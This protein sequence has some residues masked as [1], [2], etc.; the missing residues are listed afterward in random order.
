[1]RSAP[2][3]IPGRGGAGI[4]TYIDEATRALN[5][6]GHTCHLL[7]WSYD[8]GADS[9]APV[10]AGLFLHMRA[11]GPCPVE[12]GRVFPALR[13]SQLVAGWVRGLHRQF[14][15]DYAEFTDWMAPAYA[16]LQLRSIDSDLR[17]LK[18]TVFNH[19]LTYIIESNCSRPFGHAGIGRGMPARVRR[20]ASRAR[21]ERRRAVSTTERMSA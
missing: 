13:L 11:V 15:F 7:S 6:A 19:G 4:A 3:E 10:R 16:L 5:A 18:V 12:Y 2:P 21:R 8:S 17:D 9:D 20:M 14:Q 1:M